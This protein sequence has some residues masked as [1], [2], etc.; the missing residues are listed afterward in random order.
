LDEAA[1]AEK[2]PNVRL[3]IKCNLKPSMR[4]AIQRRIMRLPA[5]DTII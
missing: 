2:N 4:G 3:I 5:N 1:I